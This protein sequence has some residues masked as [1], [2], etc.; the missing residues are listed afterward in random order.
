MTTRPYELLARF[1]PDGTI[2]GVHVRTITTVEGRDFESDPEPLAS[3]SDPAFVAFAEQFAA[4]AAANLEQ[5]KQQLTEAQQAAAEA[6]AL[7][8]RVAELE[9]EL[10]L[11]RNPPQTASVTPRQIRRWLITNYGP[12]I[13]DQITAAMEAIEDP[14]HRAIAK[15]DWEFASAIYRNDSLLIQFAQM[16]GFTEEQMDR[17]FEEA[18]RI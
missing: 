6:E 2:A 15:S 9:A 11:L 7:R 12:A 13:L 5:A 4:Q 14:V 17:A 18:S 1:A 10:E 16:L 3:A 8:Q